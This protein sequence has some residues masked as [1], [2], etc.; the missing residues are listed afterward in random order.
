MAREKKEKVADEE[1]TAIISAIFA[2]IVKRTKNKWEK[3]IIYFPF[4]ELGTV[5]EYCAEMGIENPFGED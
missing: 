3:G 2:E 5:A 4:R 1:K